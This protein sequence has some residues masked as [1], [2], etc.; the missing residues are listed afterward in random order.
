M[1]LMTK[2]IIQSF[3]AKA[4]AKYEMKFC[5]DFPKTFIINSHQITTRRT[6]INKDICHY[7]DIMTMDF[8]IVVTDY[9]DVQIFYKMQYLSFISKC[10]L[11]RFFLLSTK[12]QAFFHSASSKIISRE[13]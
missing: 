13:N 5:K 6:N 4:I 11:V 7:M 9:C 1:N 3:L 10:F 12:V 2:L 8:L